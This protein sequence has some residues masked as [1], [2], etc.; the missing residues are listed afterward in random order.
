[1]ESIDLLPDLESLSGA[2]KALFWRVEEA[3]LVLPPHRS[4]SPSLPA[5]VSVMSN[6]AENSSTDKVDLKRTT[7]DPSPDVAALDYASEKSASG[8]S[9]LVLRTDL[10]IVPMM[11]ILNFGAARMD[12]LGVSMMGFKNNDYW[13]SLLVF[14]IGCRWFR[15]S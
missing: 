2:Q 4:T 13:M 7:S 11:F 9:S 6:S 3:G 8:D 5:C 15:F 14:F 12:T 1:M 10:W